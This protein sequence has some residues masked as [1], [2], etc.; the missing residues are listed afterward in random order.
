MVAAGNC[1]RFAQIK[2][3]RLLYNGQL[4]GL[5]GTTWVDGEMKPTAVLGVW[6]LEV[7]GA[8]SRNPW[9]V[10]REGCYAW[11]AWIRDKSP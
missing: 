4:L 2:V 5:A 6:D 3:L 11:L 10:F 8:G 9:T 7:K 1:P